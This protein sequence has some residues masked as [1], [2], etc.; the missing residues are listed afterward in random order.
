MVEINK[1]SIA[2]IKRAKEQK[3]LDPMFFKRKGSL[4][5]RKTD[6]PRGFAAMTPEL[7]KEIQRKG[8]A[9]RWSKKNVNE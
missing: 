1:R 3:R 8:N 2:A 6:T 4:P 9:A 5:K 7:S